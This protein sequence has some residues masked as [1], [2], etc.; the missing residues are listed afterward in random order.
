V[1]SGLFTALY[2]NLSMN[3]TININKPCHES[4]N[5]MT[6][7]AEGRL[8][9][10]CVKVVKDFTNMSDEEL[11]TYMKESKG[12]ECGRFRKDQVQPIFS[13][14]H[15]FFYNFKIRSVAFFAVMFARF[16]MADHAAAQNNPTLMEGGN[17]IPVAPK[18]IYNDSVVYHVSGNVTDMQ[19]GG[20]GHI[21]VKVEINGKA[22][23]LSVYTDGNGHFEMNITAK[24]SDDVITL[25]FSDKD[26]ETLKMKNYI[27]DGKVLDV[28]LT[29]K[30]GKKHEYV[31][32]YI[33]GDYAF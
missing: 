24:R 3:P 5:T 23:A 6:P 26:H 28:T 18:S 12:G 20:L 16:F 17:N 9:D 7:K 25:I 14:K 8:C 21:P 2:I 11:I 15:S 19:E 33:M 29:R 31:E 22:S 4:W 30:K 1:E 13:N 10:S 27:P 32:K